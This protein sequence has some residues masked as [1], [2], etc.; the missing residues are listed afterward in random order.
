MRQKI[1]FSLERKRVNPGRF[2]S[3]TFLIRRLLRYSAVASMV[4]IAALVFFP[5]SLTHATPVLYIPN[6]SSNTVSVMDGSTYSVIKTISVGQ[7]PYGVGVSPDGKSVFITNMAADTVSVIDT[8][9]N[10]VINTI[11]V[12]DSPF[13]VAVSPDGRY[14]YVANAEDDNISVIDTSGY[15]VVAHIK[16]GDGPHGMV[17]HPDGSKL[18]VTNYFGSTVSV[19]NTSTNSVIKTITVGTS[20]HGI[21]IHPSGAYVYTANVHGDSLSVISTSSNSVIKTVNTGKWPFFPAL[22]PTGQYLYV[23]NHDSSSVTVVDTSSNSV[24]GNITVGLGPHGIS[25]DATGSR[26]YVANEAG[27]SV[28]VIDT[29]SRTVITT[30]SVGTTP[31]AFG[32]S[33][34]EPKIPSP[35]GANVFTP[36]THAVIPFR[37]S[38]PG[39]AKPIGMGT[40]AGVGATLSLSVGANKFSSPMDVYLGLSMP[41]I[42]PA[43][44]YL[45]TSAGL[46][47]IS[48]G[49]L[50]WKSSVTDISGVVVSDYDAL[51]LP[52]G[53]YGFYL[54]VVP[55]GTAAAN[56]SMNYYQWNGS[57]SVIRASDVANKAIALF[58]TD[59][60]AAA[61]IFLAMDNGFSIDQIVA[62]IDA[63]SLSSIGEIQGAQSSSSG[64]KVLR[65]G[66]VADKHCG[67]LDYMNNEFDKQLCIGRIEVMLEG[68]NGNG[69]ESTAVLTAM[70]GDVG[71]S[72][73]QIDEMHQ[74]ECCTTDI[75]TLEIRCCYDTQYG[76]ICGTGWCFVTKPV[77]P[78]TN[79]LTETLDA[80]CPILGGNRDS[81]IISN[82]PFM[83]P[84]AVSPIPGLKRASASDNC[85]PTCTDNDGDGYYVQSG[86]GTGGA[87]DCNDGNSNIKPTMPENC[88]DGI[89]NNCDGMI[90]AQD[91]GCNP[92]APS[93]APCPDPANPTPCGSG[94]YPAGAV[95]CD[96]TGGAC[97]AGSQCCGTGCMPA[98]YVCCAPVGHCPPGNTCDYENKSCI[99]GTGVSD[100]MTHDTKWQPFLEG[101]NN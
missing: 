42:D 86:C 19:I 41:A 25:L 53:A 70:L 76:S 91:P 29:P 38:D 58:G 59:S 17:F 90:D 64:L 52:T 89:D 56:L 62:S 1:A 77:N 60:A 31:I 12:G 78:P 27:N 74:E 54:R 40:I 35:R 46:K 28:S 65:G 55:A 10:T 39:K 98:G 11:S 84:Q 66:T 72:A 15:S 9:A 67:D 82:N 97:A 4:G 61:A 81:R 75:P 93:P 18:Y 48:A 2:L 7:D 14:A 5:V 73:A 63:G 44:I 88:A 49:L 83:S 23:S 26:A 36:Y 13:G 100:F 22:D 68:V 57:L 20:P 92:P 71:Y 16:V 47:P 101:P 43:N 34:A 21:A 96:A 80:I 24:V 69:S 79:K 45:F 50:P 94:C 8:A 37:D 30:V 33:L 51:L 85:T 6:N 95:C 32:N 3:Y 87:V 99:S